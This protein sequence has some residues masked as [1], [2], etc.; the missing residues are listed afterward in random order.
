[1]GS[2]CV[3]LCYPHIFVSLLFYAYYFLK[4]MNYNC[5]KGNKNNSKLYI[6]FAEIFSFFLCCSHSIIFPPS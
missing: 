6:R 2:V 4:K 1:M 3:D 5:K